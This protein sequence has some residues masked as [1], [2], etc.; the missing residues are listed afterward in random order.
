MPTAELTRLAVGEWSD[1]LGDVT[2]E[3]VKQG[4]ADWCEDWPP[5]AD[6]FRKACL[7]GQAGC[8]HN[9]A[10]YKPFVALP[11]LPR[12]KA[13]GVAALAAMRGAL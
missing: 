6:E 1:R 10:A 11:K 9:T 8:L 2:G 13:V 12:D 3:Q 4:L 7:G 5:S